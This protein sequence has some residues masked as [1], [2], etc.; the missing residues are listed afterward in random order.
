[1]TH[2]RSTAKSRR[3]RLRL[4]YQDLSKGVNTYLKCQD[5][6]VKIR[7]LNKDK[8][9]GNQECAV[10]SYVNQQ[11]ASMC[12]SGNVLSLLHLWFFFNI[13]SLICLFLCVI[14]CYSLPLLWHNRDLKSLTHNRTVKN[15]NACFALHVGAAKRRPSPS[16]SHLSFWSF[17]SSSHSSGLRCLT[18]DRVQNQPF[19]RPSISNRY[20]LLMA[21]NTVNM[22]KISVSQGVFTV[23][24][25]RTWCVCARMTV[26]L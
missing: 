12:S 9:W 4:K 8:R 17:H 19:N 7:N 25:L 6:E 21:Q 16:W 10:G 14:F 23:R 13:F 26:K 5:T 2:V 3:R 1:M 18:G 20:G 22:S 15:S 11:P 24:A